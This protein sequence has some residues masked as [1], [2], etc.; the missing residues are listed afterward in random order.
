MKIK[1]LKVPE[2]VIDISYCNSPDW[3]AV[4]KSGVSAVIIRAGYYSNGF[5]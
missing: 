5:W 3:S 1:M 4:K 2:N